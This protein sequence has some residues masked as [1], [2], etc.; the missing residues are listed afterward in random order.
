MNQGRARAMSSP[1]FNQGRRQRMTDSQSYQ[2]LGAAPSSLL[3]GVHCEGTNLSN[4]KK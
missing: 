3:E 2:A 4:A 1:I